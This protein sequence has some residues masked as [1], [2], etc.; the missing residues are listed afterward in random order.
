MAIRDLP[1]EPPSKVHK[2]S[3]KL[4]I[5]RSRDLYSVI[6]GC[7]P[8]LAGVN[9]FRSLAWVSDSGRVGILASHRENKE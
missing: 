4:C 9:C 2:D 1:D 7:Q 5:S 3:I 8:L 6:F